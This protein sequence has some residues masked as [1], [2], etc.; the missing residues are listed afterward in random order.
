MLILGVLWLGLVGVVYA[1][2]FSSQ[3]FQQSFS[4]VVEV[5]KEMQELQSSLIREDE[6]LQ[7]AVQLRQNTTIVGEERNTRT[8]LIVSAVI[9]KSCKNNEIY[10]DGIMRHVAHT[11]LAEY[12]GAR[13]VDILTVSLVHQSHFFIVTFSTAQVE[14]LS[15][16]EW[17]SLLAEPLK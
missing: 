2:I 4:S 3:W 15:I 1:L 12:E 11:T 13:E 9:E 7:A 6:I 16:E 10:C 8:E 5:G 17:E 14:S